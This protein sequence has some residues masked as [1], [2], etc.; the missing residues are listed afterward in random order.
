MGRQTNKTVLD[1]NTICKEY[2][3]RD[4]RGRALVVTAESPMV[5]KE[6]SGEEAFELNPEELGVEFQGHEEGHFKQTVNSEAVRLGRAW[7]D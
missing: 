3:K 5:R 6:L 1:S 4:R 2:K 7:C